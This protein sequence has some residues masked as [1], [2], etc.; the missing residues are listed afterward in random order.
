MHVN[1]RAFRKHK[2]P[3]DCN[4]E[5]VSFNEHQT[6]YEEKLDSSYVARA[7][8]QIKNIYLFVY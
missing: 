1:D 6:V 3:K 2:K 5:F 8:V 7:T 4:C